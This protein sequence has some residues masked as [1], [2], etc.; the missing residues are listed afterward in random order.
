MHMGDAQKA[1]PHLRGLAFWAFVHTGRLRDKSAAL[2]T[3]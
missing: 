2:L 1:S 3:R